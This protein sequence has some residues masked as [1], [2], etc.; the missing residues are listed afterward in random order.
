MHKERFGTQDVKT[1]KKKKI[2]KSTSSPNEVSEYI[3]VFYTIF[4]KNQILVENV[5]STTQK[6]QTTECNFSIINP[7]LFI[8]KTLYMH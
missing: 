2:I 3:P 1:C 5:P 8:K 6:I 4:F 7:I